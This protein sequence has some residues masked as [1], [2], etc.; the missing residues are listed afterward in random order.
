MPKF[1]SMWPLSLSEGWRA[2][3]LAEMHAVV[4]VIKN[5]KRSRDNGD[6]RDRNDGSLPH[7]RSKLPS[8]QD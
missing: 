6:Q 5:K 4:Q 2:I 7:E 8:L 1:T 3:Q